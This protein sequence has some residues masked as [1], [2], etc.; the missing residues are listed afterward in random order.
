MKSV[1]IF[2]RPPTRRSWMMFT[3][4]VAKR[5]WLFFHSFGRF[6]RI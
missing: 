3:A 6:R 2:G 5:E 4:A 1:N